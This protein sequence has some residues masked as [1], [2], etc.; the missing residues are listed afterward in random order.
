MNL[1][2]GSYEAV[3]EIQRLNKFIFKIQLATQ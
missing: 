3:V 1:I 2:P